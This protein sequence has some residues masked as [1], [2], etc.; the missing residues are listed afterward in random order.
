[1]NGKGYRVHIIT[2]CTICVFYVCVW[3]RKPHQKRQ[4]VEGWLERRCKCC[5]GD[6]SEE[7]VWRRLTEVCSCLQINSECKLPNLAVSLNLK[8][9]FHRCTRH[10]LII[11]TQTYVSF[12]PRFPWL[13]NSYRA[14]EPYK[15]E[16]KKEKKKKKWQRSKGIEQ[17]YANTSTVLACELSFL[18]TLKHHPGRGLSLTWQFAA[19]FTWLLWMQRD[20]QTPLCP[21]LL[22]VV[23]EESPL[24]PSI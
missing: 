24:R 8:Q 13:V 1:M 22:S 7:W 23:A 19:L 17:I 16:R 20:W 12:P 4:K 18:V 21:Q 2:Y 3:G 9:S 15:R 6:E 5:A 14:P 10:T 11:K